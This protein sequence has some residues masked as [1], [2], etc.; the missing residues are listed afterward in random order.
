MK[1]GYLG[2]AYTFEELGITAINLPKTTETTLQNNFDGRENNL[3]T[4][5]GATF[6]VDGK[7][8]TYADIWH[9]IRE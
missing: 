3:M 6:V 2:E 5:N 9:K 8:Q 4:Q 7:E 1:N